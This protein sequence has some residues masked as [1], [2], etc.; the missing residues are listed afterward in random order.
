MTV[1]PGVVAVHR[2][3]GI[4]P[5]LLGYLMG[6]LAL[7]VVL[8]MRRFG[9]VADEPV[10]L[11][12]AVFVAVP[13]I[14]IVIDRLTEHGPN[15]GILQLR[16]AWHATAVAT[17]IYLTGWG[18]V[19]I[20]AFAI[21]ALENI[22][23]NG[24]R[25]WRSTAGWSF[26]AIA[27]GQIAIWTS[28]A[29]SFLSNREA[30]A[31]ALMEAFVLLFV[32]RMAGATMEQ[33]EHAED[34]FRSLVQNSS[35]VT[36]VVGEGRL[37]T[38]ASPATA[39]LLGRTP[40]MVMRR[41]VDEFVHPEDRDSVKLQIADRLQ[42]QSAT[43]PVQFRMQHPDGTWRYVEAVVSDLRD[44]PSV[45][46][47]VANVRDITE[48]KEVEDLLAHQA[49]HD[50]LTGLPNRTLILDR[51]D[52]MLVRARRELRPVAALFI[53][54]DN[55]KDVNDTF[56]HAT[57]DWILQGVAKRFAS[58]VRKSDT[59]GRLGGDEFVVLADDDTSAT[60]PEMLAE[61]LQKV[62]R[63]PFRVEGFEGTLT[64]SASVGIAAGDRQS[65]PDLLR[66]ADI[67]L[68]RAKALGK[69]GS[70]SFEPGMQSAL[71]DRLE[72]R[73]DLQS[74]LANNQFFLLYQ[75][76]LD[77]ESM[78]VCAVEALLR[79]RHPVRGT[80][81]PDQFIPLLEETGLIADVGAWVLKR[82]C[83]QGAEWNRRGHNLRVL[84]NVSARQL[85]T[86]A[87]V[88]QLRESLAETQIEPNLLAMEVTET[89]I[90]RDTDATVDRFRRIKE[91]GVQIAIDDFGTG[92]SSLACLR[93]FPVDALKIDGSF[94]AAMDDSSESSALIHTLVELGRTLGL[95]TI[96]EGI[97]D[98]SQLIRLQNEG[99]DRGQGFLFS[100]ALSPGGI[101][102]FLLQTPGR[103]TEQRGSTL[104]LG[105]DHRYA[106]SPVGSQ[107]DGVGLS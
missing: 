44:Q 40:D 5:S 2:R 107:C 3:R 19:L 86:D 72:L 52:Q 85:E 75:P 93:Q 36:L 13:S 70:V 91:L 74:A 97:E 20:G 28:W 69:D 30:Q 78:S 45:A 22:S 35:D 43:D 29:P 50:P 55:F 77:L 9:L 101:E 17:V 41:P 14:S 46:G 73:R 83:R 1:A 82:A 51:T 63:E 94:I 95:E 59:V 92:Y 27:V 7:A 42:R 34:R 21:I 100:P 60:R 56:G 33:K 106:A 23:H 11:W 62:L 38:Y 79:W 65:A 8:A 6:P 53:D 16:V 64:L 96:A 68:Y 32:I 98:Q 12:L 84:V 47:Y 49:L 88:E 10:W 80:V 81:L 54:L 71:L 102:E 87:L 18:P 24:S 57:G 26:A 89:S 99:C 4:D 90:M 39:A 104:S 103:S 25:S 31:L 67:A 105:T 61:R 66:D 48:R 58:I 15:D 76:I 37:V